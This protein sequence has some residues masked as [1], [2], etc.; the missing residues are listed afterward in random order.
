MLRLGQH[1]RL[2]RAEVARF[3]RLTDMAPVGIRRV[4]DLDAYMARCKAHYGGVSN[5]TRFLHWLLDQ[6]YRQCRRAE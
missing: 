5:E 6:E 3:E 1:I 4:Q 2:T